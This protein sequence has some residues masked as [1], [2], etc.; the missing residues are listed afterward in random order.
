MC[1]TACVYL[2]L[3][4]F[5]NFH[6]EVILDTTFVCLFALQSMVCL[7]ISSYPGLLDLVSPALGDHCLLILGAA[8]DDSLRAS[9]YKV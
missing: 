3:L 1:I 9:I 8:L 6:L 5:E 4:A 7:L 2:C